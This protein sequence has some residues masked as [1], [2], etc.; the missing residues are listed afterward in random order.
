MVTHSHE[1]PIRLFQVRP[2]LAAELLVKSLGAAFPAYASAL[3][4]SEALTNND[5]LE[6]NCDNAAVFRD[7]AGVPVFAVIIE[8]QRGQDNRKRYSWPMYTTIL[9]ARLKCPVRL[10]AICTDAAT[11]DWARR[12]I[13]IG[14][15][16]FTLLPD[17]I[18]PEDL[19]E[20][21]EDRAKEAVEI[22]ILKAACRGPQAEQVA[23]KLGRRLNELSESDRQQYAGLAM[24]LLSDE[25]CTVLEEYMSM[26][27]QE[28]L[29][30]P[31]GKLELK[32]EQRG[33]QRGRRLGQ[34]GALLKVLDARGIEVS[35]SAL[36]RI[37][38]VSDEEELDR[39]F[40]RAVT[41]DRVEEI[42]D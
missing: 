42:F 26:T 27:Y 10:L 12:A 5:P 33:E 14:P 3:P 30:S 1:V 23:H 36:A 8:I 2:E 15:P 17:V 4:E 20:I 28:Y 13:E 25:A 29:E 16:G 38:G 21:D 41:V 32:G 24:Q 9:R 11:A 19:M 31:A 18:N 40:I 6:L 35:S 37:E 34:I 22:L 39:W 7:E